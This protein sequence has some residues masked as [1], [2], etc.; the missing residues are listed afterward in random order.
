MFSLT[1]VATSLAFNTNTPNSPIII[2]TSE[3]LT[4]IVTE[5]VRKRRRGVP[6]DIAAAKIQKSAR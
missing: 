2:N 6:S 5:D 3:T 4:T 1:Y